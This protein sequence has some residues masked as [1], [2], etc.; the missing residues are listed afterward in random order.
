ML[1]IRAME[2]QKIYNLSAQRINF[3]CVTSM[4]PADELDQVLLTLDKACSASRDL[5]VE[6]SASP[7]SADLIQ[8]M[9]ELDCAW[10]NLRAT[11]QAAKLKRANAAV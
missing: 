6:I 4:A 9:T 1:E 11:V 3:I 5:C 2:L 8:D 7:D 10:A